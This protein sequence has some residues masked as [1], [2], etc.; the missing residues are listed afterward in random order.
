MEQKVA[1]VKKKRKR[2]SSFYILKF[3]F[4]EAHILILDFYVL[5]NWH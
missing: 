3:Y 1:A 2:K 5:I 4:P